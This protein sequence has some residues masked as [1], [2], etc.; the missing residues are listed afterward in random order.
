MKK[1]T[2]YRIV[3]V[4]VCCVFAA[5]GII[6]QNQQRIRSQ[7]HGATE[8]AHKGQLSDAHLIGDVVDKHSGE[9]LPFINI[10]LKGTSIGTTTDETGHY[11]LKNLPVG[12]FILQ[13]SCVGYDSQEIPI[14]IVQ[15]TTQEINIVLEESTPISTKWLLPATDTK[16]SSEK[17]PQWLISFLR[18]C[19]KTPHRAMLPKYFRFN[20][21][22]E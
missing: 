15:N 12:E 21:D 1:I 16:P 4:V 13:I 17:Q 8:T 9:H 3:A 6:A 20:P 10:Q 11:F 5:D 2:F 7:Q 19:L 18:N 22:C 14:E